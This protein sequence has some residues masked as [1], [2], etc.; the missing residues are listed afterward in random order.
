LGCGKAK[1]RF[2]RLASRFQLL[3]LRPALQRRLLVR[4]GGCQRVLGTLDFGS[5]PKVLSLHFCLGLPL[6]TG[7]RGPLS[8]SGVC[9][10]A[11]RLELLSSEARLDLKTP[12]LYPGLLLPCNI[13]LHH[14]GCTLETGSSDR[15]D[16][17]LLCFTCSLS[18]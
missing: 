2:F 6:L 1:P 8:A 17:T 16:I 11:L 14:L 13:G 4:L 7:E 18:R 12:T 10:T 5:L 9:L 3:L 15:S